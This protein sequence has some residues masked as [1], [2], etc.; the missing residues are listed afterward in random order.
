VIVGRAGNNTS[1]VRGRCAALGLEDA[2]LCTGERTDIPEVLRAADLFALSSDTEGM[3]LSALEAMAAG[4]PVVA[5]SVGG[6]ADVVID[7]ITGRLVRTGDSGAF[8][9]AIVE[10][11]MHPEHGRV[12]VQTA[13]TRLDAF[14]DARTWAAR[15]SALYCELATSRRWHL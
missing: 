2:V 3:P 11:L 1:V 13:T 12:I 14:H 15:L 7:G 4:I 6:V 9:S 5:T 10:T 8:A